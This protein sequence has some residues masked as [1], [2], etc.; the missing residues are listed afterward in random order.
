MEDHEHGVLSAPA[1]VM[2]D[3]LQFVVSLARDPVVN[4]SPQ[5]SLYSLFV[6][7][8]GGHIA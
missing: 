2:S 6:E 7:V 4:Q 1:T 3:K 5:I 8:Q